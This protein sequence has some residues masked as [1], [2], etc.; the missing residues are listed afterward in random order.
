MKSFFQFNEALQPKAYEVS[1]LGEIGTNT[2]APKL[3]DFTYPLVSFIQQ[4]LRA[5]GLFVGKESFGIFPYPM[6]CLDDVLENSEAKNYALGPVEGVH[7]KIFA[8]KFI[9]QNSSLDENEEGKAI[10]T[11]NE[12]GAMRLL[13]I[14]LRKIG[15]MKPGKSWRETPAIDW[16]KFFADINDGMHCI[17]EKFLADM[18]PRN[19]GATGI[20]H[21]KL[22]I[23]TNWEYSY[24]VSQKE[25]L[26]LPATFKPIFD[27]LKRNG[28]SVSLITVPAPLIPQFLQQVENIES[29]M[30]PEDPLKPSIEDLKRMIN[31]AKT[32]N[33]GIYIR[34]IGNI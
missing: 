9:M 8:E 22:Q 31:T 19:F 4:Y 21:G 16:N 6:E 1:F 5:K 18:K 2:K 3:A 24:D 14:Y 29:E 30:L 33:I 34:G 10:F 25:K 12:T 7:T 15:G 13:K 17:I 11:F 32:K 27:K 23:V 26:I 28:F 20:S